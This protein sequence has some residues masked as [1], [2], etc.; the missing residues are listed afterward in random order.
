MV[1]T[2]K[3]DEKKNNQEEKESIEEKAP[4]KTT[5]EEKG[6]EMEEEQGKEDAEA[7]EIVEVPE[8][9]NSGFVR[10][11]EEWKPRSQLG[12]AVATGKI[13]DINIILDNGMKILEAEIIDQLLPNLD[14]ELLLVGQSKG[15]FG[16]G[17][18]RVFKQTQKK[19][20]EGN[21]PKFSTIVIIGN[22]N[23]IIGIG[24]G[25]S[26]ETVPARE[27]ATRNA[28]L[29]IIKIVR[30]CGSW[31]CGCGEPHSLPFKVSGKV[32]SSKI[33]L[34]PAPKGTGLIVEPEIAK[35]LKMAGIKDAW[36]RT[37]GQT[38]TKTNMIYAC[39]EALKEL[40]RMKINPQLKREIS[41]TEGS[42]TEE[43]EKE[44][45]EE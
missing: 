6:K 25:K 38:K 12:K 39:F 28:K 30:G 9:E 21:K 37:E 17:Q 32:G 2:I 7:E 3:M 35:I 14:S 4:Q 42:I 24:K 19:T 10:V 36:S 11:S 27:K 22:H 33:T 23:G 8:E 1:W 13:R 29:N 18:R 15:K 31:E 40:T 44:A 41:I 45:V 20:N 16:G 5:E 43:S 26:K 34:I